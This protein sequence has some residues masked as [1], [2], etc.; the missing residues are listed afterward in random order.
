[1][2]SFSA[3][4]VFCCDVHVGSVANLEELTPIMKPAM[5]TGTIQVVPHLWLADGPVRIGPVRGLLGLV[6]GSEQG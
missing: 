2:L 5:L 3:T 4:F 6:V 1:M